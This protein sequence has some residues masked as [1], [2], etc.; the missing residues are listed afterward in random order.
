M[1]VWLRI[2]LVLFLVVAAVSAV[3]A[4]DV[5]T[6]P[7]CHAVVEVHKG[8]CPDCGFN[9]YALPIDE[10][11]R[12]DYREKTVTIFSPG[13]GLVRSTLYKHTEFDT[14]F[15]FTFNN[16]GESYAIHIV[17]YYSKREKVHSFCLDSFFQFFLL[18]GVKVNPH[19]GVGMFI[20]SYFGDGMVVVEFAPI[21]KFGIMVNLDNRGSFVDPYIGY[22]LY[23][24]G[25]VSGGHHNTLRTLAFGVFSN[26]LFTRSVGIGGRLEWMK[27]PGFDHPDKFA[28]SFGPAIVF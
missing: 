26:L 9:F 3:Y 24:E 25:D 8:E 4:G 21:P 18:R 7:R 11:N 23:L 5:K 1:K 15:P 2:V 12:L 17:P 14:M 20:K 10:N 28:G 16:I 6:C 13:I 27:F 19:L 22:G